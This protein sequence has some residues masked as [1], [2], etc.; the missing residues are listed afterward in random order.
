MAQRIDRAF[1]RSESLLNVRLV[2]HHPRHALE[3][4]DRRLGR[5]R[6]HGIF[7]LVEIGTDELIA[8]FIGDQTHDLVVDLMQFFE[9]RVEQRA[10]AQIVDASRYA[11]R[12]RVNTFE[13]FVA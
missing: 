12:E 9:K 3:R 7:G 8:D 1:E 10:I 11:L 6:R 2:E 5:L 13:R 4:L